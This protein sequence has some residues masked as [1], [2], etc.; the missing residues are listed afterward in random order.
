MI[1]LIFIRSCAY[2]FYIVLYIVNVISVYYLFRR[3]VAKRCPSPPMHNLLSVGAQHQGIQTIKGAHTTVKVVVFTLI[4]LFTNL[5][6]ILFH[7]IWKIKALVY[8]TLLCIYWKKNSK[9]VNEKQVYVHLWPI[10]TSYQLSSAIKKNLFMNSSLKCK[11]QNLW[12]FCPN[13]KIKSSSLCSMER[14]ST[15]YNE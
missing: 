15:K 2:P 5:A 7:N 3:A 14:V 9:F 4:F 1:T 10:T 11:L 13:T 12:Q 8:T 6:L